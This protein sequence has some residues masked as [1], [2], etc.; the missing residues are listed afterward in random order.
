METTHLITNVVISIFPSMAEG[1]KCPSD[2]YD[3]LIT[4]NLNP[5]YDDVTFRGPSGEDQLFT[6]LA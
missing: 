4:V 3:F 2:I 6:M 1:E 5:T